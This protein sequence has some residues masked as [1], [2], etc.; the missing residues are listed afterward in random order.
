MVFKAKNAHTFKVKFSIPTRND[1]MPRTFSTGA[2][3]KSVA[4]DVE[5]MVDRM[6]GRR[7][8]APL[9]AVFD[10]LLS[11]AEVYDADVAGTLAARMAALRDVDLEPM[12]AEWAKRADPKYVRQARRLFVE[13]VRFPRSEFRR[14]RVSDFLDGLD[15]DNP[16]R[17]RYRAALSSFAKWLVQKE[18][19][20]FNV[21]RTV[22]MYPEND[23]RMVWM[24]WAQAIKVADA[25]AEPYRTLFRLM[26]ATGME[27]GAALKL[28]LQ[29][30]QLDEQTIAAH[31]SKTSWR[32]RVIRFEEWATYNL[33][34]LCRPLTGFAPLFDGINGDTALDVWKEAQKAVGI[35]GHTLHD[36]RH[37]YAVNALKKGYKEQVVAT[38]LGHKNTNQVRTCYGRFIPDAADYEVTKTVT[39]AKKP[40]EVKRAK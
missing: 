28:N 17:N 20:E 40:R 4:Q 27:L 16:T 35:E 30:V 9:E 23:P 31:G 5:R 22:S 13:G 14:K 10:N 25:A 18:V 21:V 12:V 39:S 33:R 7:D 3:A 8:W 26:A 11:L 36:L 15:V 32:N 29:D 6:K 2:T 37:T 19:V 24:P 34:G 1:G 38:Q